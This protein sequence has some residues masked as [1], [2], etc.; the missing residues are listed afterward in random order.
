MKKN[1]ALGIFVYIC[2]L[3]AAVGVALGLIRPIFD[4][5]SNVLP[6]NGIVWI[7]LALLAGVLVNAILL[8]FG[9]FVGAK[10]GKYQIVSWN[11]LF[12]KFSK[13]KE[14]KTAFTL[15]NYDGITGET[16]VVPRDVHTSNPRHIIYMPM[17]FFLLE[18]VIGVFL[19]VFSKILVN[20]GITVWIWGYVFVIVV[21]TIGGMIFVYNFFPA[22]LDA[23]NDG[24]LIPIL[25]NSTNV[26]AYNQMLLSQYR[27]SQGL[28]VGQTPI[29]DKVTDFTAKANA[30]AIYKRLEQ[31][32]YAG[33]LQINEYTIQC[34]DSVSSKV[35]H[36]AV[37][38]K[39]AIHLYRENFVKAKEEYIALPL[40]DKKF[41]AEL[42]TA[43]AVRAYM[44]ISGLIEES[45]NET[46]LAMN[47][48]D[49]AIR[50][51]GEDKRRV[52]ERMMKDAF[53]KIVKAHPDWDFGEY[54]EFFADE[55]TQE[56]DTTSA[57]K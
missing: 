46:K 37:A 3:G 31:A 38:Q 22:S 30:I 42:S 24:Y 17:L 14:G 13:N 6:M 39:I 23:R 33:A 20:D 51:S 29:Y 8:E 28:D 52:E 53:K 44:L 35:Y 4:T 18:V 7:L 9:H 34:K 19:I 47:K 50:A 49:D 11:C 1:T 25:N 27:L 56:S 26:L 57:Q 45:I 12:L 43:P 10:I 21:L 36:D 5:Y 15:A 16:I 40:E 48:A 54:K 55:N 2:M 41:I 32:D